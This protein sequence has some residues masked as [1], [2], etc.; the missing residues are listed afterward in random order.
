MEQKH[1]AAGTGGAY[2][3]DTLC[4]GVACVGCDNQRIVAGTM[5]QLLH[6]DFGPPLHSMVLCGELHECELEVLNAYRVPSTPPL[7]PKSTEGDAIPLQ[8]V[9]RWPTS[10]DSDSSAAILDSVLRSCCD[11]DRLRQVIGSASDR[12]VELSRR[13]GRDQCPPPAPEQSETSVPART[14]VISQAL[15]QDA[16]SSATASHTLVHS[17][18]PR[19]DSG[20]QGGAE[21][22][23]EGDAENVN[24]FLGDL[25]DSSDD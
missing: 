6:V 7:M 15:G 8:Q 13:A 11:P 23:F 25:I 5:G 21:I 22:A 19:K 1:K 16:M 10:L 9:A 18:L 14:S 17:S 12:L 3:E 4:V 2:D 20:L 24:E